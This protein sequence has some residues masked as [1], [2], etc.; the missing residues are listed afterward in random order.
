ME[1]YYNFICCFINECKSK[2]KEVENPAD[3][4]INLWKPLA[5]QVVVLRQARTASDAQYV[6][7]AF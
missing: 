5:S 1:S 3:K 2:L 4:I 6:T 7:R